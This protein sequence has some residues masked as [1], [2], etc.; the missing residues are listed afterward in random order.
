MWLTRKR[1][2]PPTRKCIVKA[3][4]GSSRSWAPSLPNQTRFQVATNSMLSTPH[5]GRSHHVTHGFSLPLLPSVLTRS[6]SLPG[7]KEETHSKCS[8]YLAAACGFQT[9]GPSQASESAYIHPNTEQSL[10]PTRESQAALPDS[11]WVN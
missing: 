6:P 10:L 3:T 9:Q 4:D 11:A 5:T 2:V 1:C 7:C 8:H